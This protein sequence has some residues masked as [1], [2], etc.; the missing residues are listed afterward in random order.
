[1]AVSPLVRQPPHPRPNQTHSRLTQ[2][3]GRHF[4]QE[5]P[6]HSYGMVTRS[7]SLSSDLRILEPPM[8]DLFATRWNHQ[9]PTFVSR[10]PDPEVWAM[11]TLSIRWEGLWAYA[12]PPTVL[13]PKILQRLMGQNCQMILIAP[14]SWN[15][16]WITD[17]FDLSIDLPRKPPAI[18]HLFQ[19]PR[20]RVFHL[21]SDRLLL[22]AWLLSGQPC[23][24]NNLNIQLWRASQ[25]Q[26]G[27][28]L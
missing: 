11:Y 12:Y 3:F 8:I 26:D 15:K 14:L 16:S 1:M 24:T 17:L 13:V 10:V 4:I 9:L 6:N 2:C 20:S 19:Q 5:M 18:P 7:F 22:H 28:P 27:P 21:C 23:K 25:E